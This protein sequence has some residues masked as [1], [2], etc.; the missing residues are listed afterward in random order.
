MK[1][2][3]KYG[4]VATTSFLAGIGT[5]AAIGLMVWRQTFNL[6][7][8]ELKGSNVHRTDFTVSRKNRK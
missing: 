1:Q 3:V 2:N 8:E 6:I 7:E 4:I 5:V